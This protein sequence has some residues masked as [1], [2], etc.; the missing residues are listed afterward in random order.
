MGRVPV[1]IDGSVIL[2]ESAAILR[3]LGAK[4]GGD[5]FWPSDPARLASLDVWAEWGKNTFT[6]AV[7][8]IFVY[9]VRLDPDTRDPAI[10]ERATAKLVPL[11][12]ILDRRIGDGHWLDG[13]TFSFA[14]ITVGHILHRY[15]SLEWDRPELTNLSAYYDRLQSRPAFREH[16]TVSYED[17]RGSY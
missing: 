8:E 12:Q 5:S 7:L 14:D 16:V 3:Y 2:F 4:Y 15:H 10:L 17:L 13:D 6:E 9:D 11:A 1:L